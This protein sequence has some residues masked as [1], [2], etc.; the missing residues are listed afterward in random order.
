MFYISYHLLILLPSNRAEAF[1]EDKSVTGK[2]NL[3]T[4]RRYI[5]PLYSYLFHYIPF[6]EV[7]HCQLLLFVFSPQMFTDV[8]PFPERHI[9]GIIQCRHYFLMKVYLAFIIYATVLSA[10]QM[11][12]NLILIIAYWIPLWYPFFQVRKLRHRKES[13]PKK[14]KKKKSSCANSLVLKIWPLQ[15]FFFFLITVLCVLLFFV[16]TQT[17]S[18]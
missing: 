2:R 14:K 5:S 7:L 4:L 13:L 16:L 3:H 9:V 1:E 8:L 15:A 12:I 10:L 17:L 6:L 11:V 18:F